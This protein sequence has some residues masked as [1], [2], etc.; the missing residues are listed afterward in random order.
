MA[1]ILLRLALVAVL[2]TAAV[3]GVLWYAVAGEWIKAGLSAMVGNVLVAM[4]R[5]AS[6]QTA[7][8]AQFI[9]QQGRGQ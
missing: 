5:P 6:E 4:V 8:L 9:D 3:C 7:Q 1:M 2:A